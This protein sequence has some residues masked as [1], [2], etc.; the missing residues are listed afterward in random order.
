MGRSV[1]MS[2]RRFL[3]SAAALAGA[4]S[5]TLRGAHAADG[6]KFDMIIVGGGTAGMPAAI[7][8]AERGGKVLVLEKYTLIGGTLDRSSGQMS[9]AGTTLQKSK[10]IVDTPDNHY[11]DIMRINRGTSDPAL[12]RLFVDNAADTLN[13]LFANGLKPG[14]DHPVKTG[15]HEP[16]TTARYQWG[17]KN[18][19]S[20]FEAMKPMFDAA[21]GKGR[22]TLGL[23]TR[24]IELMQDGKGAVTGVITEDSGGTKTEYRSRNVVMTTGGCAGDPETFMAFH[25]IPLYALRA[26]PAATGDGIK[27]GVAAGG[28]VRGADR[29][30]GSFGG[31]LTSYDY[32]AEVDAPLM[33]VPQRRQ[34]WELFVNTRGQRFMRED[35]PSVDYR[36]RSLLRQAGQRAF[37]VFD[38]AILDQAPPLM[39]SWPKEKFQSAFDGRHPMFHKADTVAELAAKVGA[40]IGVMAKSVADFNIAQISGTDPTGR[41]HEPLPITKAPFYAIAIHATT[42]ISFAGLAVDDQLRVIK[43]D[44]SAVPNLYAAGEI[45]GAGT[46]MGEAYV[47]GAMVTPALTFGRLLGQKMLKFQA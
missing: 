41:T 6:G 13:W 12:T 2:K 17:P 44:G 4:G 14:A 1:T 28:Y 23:N 38:Q 9:A 46:T 27:M 15:G 45:L 26:H 7:F 42:L 36:E 24:V 16:Y 10:G 18:G 34:P 20:I 22:V 21:V 37:V 30:L 5:L 43:P 8:A 35:H 11:N 3:Q 19:V 32:P 40:D 47:N 25:G 33:L 31:L 29:Y 39:P